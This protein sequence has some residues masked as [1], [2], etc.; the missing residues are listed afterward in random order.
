[1]KAITLLRVGKFAVV[2]S[3]GI[4]FVL[5]AATYGL[6]QDESVLLD[7]HKRLGTPNIERHDRDRMLFVAEIVGFGPRFQGV[8]KEAVDEKVD[9][10]V[11]TVLLGNPPQPVVCAGYETCS[12][13][14]PS[15]PLLC[16]AT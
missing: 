1:M 2:W 6:G 15:P 8:C 9:F 4:L 7:I 11:T 16:T 3:V 13:T 14:L 12:R 5:L 10:R